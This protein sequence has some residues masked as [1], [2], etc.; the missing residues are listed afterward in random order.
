MNKEFKCNKEHKGL[1][2]C[3]ARYLL[4]KVGGS[5]DS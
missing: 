5:H 3:Y 4:S 1:C 2:T